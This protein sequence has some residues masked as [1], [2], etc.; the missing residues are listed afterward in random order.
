MNPFDELT[1]NQAVNVSALK[2]L[3]VHRSRLRS[4]RA[5][6]ANAYR[7][8][9]AC[10]ALSGFEKGVEI[11][12]FTKGQFSLVEFTDAVLDVTGPAHISLATWTAGA[13][14]VSAILDWRERGRILSARWLVDFTFQR[15]TPELAAKIREFFGRDAIRVARNHSKFV[16]FTNSSWRVVI[17]TS[18]NLNA[19]PRFEY[20]QV[21]HDPARADFLQAMLDEIWSVQPSSLAFESAGTVNR[22]F[23]ENL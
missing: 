23:K 1:T 20:F 14:D 2:S 18:M 15:R 11:F 22:F 8:E 13:N 5:R 9:S 4:E 17:L 21:A 10:E 3:S 12:G 7:K 19:N 16:L 6:I